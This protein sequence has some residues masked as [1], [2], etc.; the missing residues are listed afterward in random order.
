MKPSLLDL[1]RTSTPGLAGRP[2]ARPYDQTTGG[3]ECARP[4]PSEFGT[5][6]VEATIT[7]W[8]SRR[9]RAAVIDRVAGS[10]QSDSSINEGDDAR[11]VGA[12]PRR[13][14]RLGE[15]SR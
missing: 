2:A 4:P 5:G 8:I 13:R 7:A 9:M 6:Q 10:S 12:A 1:V 15:G 14:H 3:G 11:A